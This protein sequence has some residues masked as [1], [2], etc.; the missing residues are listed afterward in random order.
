MIYLLNTPW[1]ILIDLVNRFGDF[2]L[3]YNPSIDDETSFVD[4][5]NCVNRCF[6]FMK[7][8]NEN[9][10]VISN[11]INKH[12]SDSN[13]HVIIWR[14][15][16]SLLLKIQ[17][18][19]DV[20]VMDKDSKILKK[21]IVSYLDSRLSGSSAKIDSESLRCFSDMI[22]A[23][24][25]SYDINYDIVEMKY[26]PLLLKC[27]NKDRIVRNDIYEVIGD[28]ML[29]GDNALFALYS[30]GQ[31]DLFFYILKEQ[32]NGKIGYEKEVFI[33][34]IINYFEHEMRLRLMIASM[35][36]SGIS[37][38][39]IINDISFMKKIKTGKSTYSKNQ[40]KYFLSRIS[41][42]NADSIKKA[43]EFKLIAIN[44]C[45]KILRSNFSLIFKDTHVTF[46]IMYLMDMI[47]FRDFYSVVSQ[48]K[49]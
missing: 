5:F 38:D 6:I 45:R 7:P 11:L 23:S 22:G 2:D 9:A 21:D 35:L 14:P 30:K 46:V 12:K 43:N 13:N 16:K 4:I 1:I 44:S 29:S 17:K 48:L 3:I 24:N 8:K 40:I 20:E 49:R 32:M 18:N 19:T 41:L 37:G 34:K 33:S 15:T 10:G 27:I 42:D 47:R 26:R 25:Y 31:T 28:E 36:L 39:S